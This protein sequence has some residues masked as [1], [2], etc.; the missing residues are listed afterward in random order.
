MR[1]SRFELSHTEKVRRSIFIFL[2]DELERR[3][4]SIAFVDTYRACEEKGIPYPFVDQKETRP[5]PKVFSKESLEFTPFFIIFCEDSIQEEHQ[6][7]IRFSDSNKVRKDNIRLVPDVGLHK[8]F[9]SGVHFFER[10][11]F[12][13]LLKS[14]LDV[15]YCLLIQ[16]DY[17]HRKR[18]RYALTHFHV[19]ID[20]PIA[21][22]AE[23]LAKEL[24]YISKSI[25]ERGEG[26]ANAL[27]QKLF[28]YYGCHHQSAG[29][30]RTAA[31]SAAQYL[32]N[33]PGLSS[34]YILS[35]EA[36][37]FTRYSESGVGRFAVIQLEK[38]QATQLMNTNNLSIKAF[39]QG[40]VLGETD[41]FFA[42]ILFIL[43]RHTKWGLPP[44]D[45]KLRIL[46]PDYSWLGVDIE[47]VLPLP[48]SEGFRPLPI[49]WVYKA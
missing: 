1:K 42:V 18:N 41:T 17:R 25:Y 26:Y 38:K 28:E 19:K 5:K 10:E 22:A 47:L 11:S 20:W 16:R 35:S 39:R 40:Y 15:D 23:S 13:E 2:R 9:Y 32:K 30:R 27:Q 12:F 4:L 46:R 14:L 33:I 7:Y 24:R 45:G 37:T 3:L 48:H 31:L 6:K 29:G 43:Y 49:K 21:D 8:T 44:P 34:V 36:R